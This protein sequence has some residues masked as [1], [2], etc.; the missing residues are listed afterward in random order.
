MI[1]ACLQNRMLKLSHESMSL[2]PHQIAPAGH[3]LDILHRSSSALDGSDMG[4]GKT[5]IAAYVA[6]QLGLPTLAV[7]PK[8][9]ISAWHRAAA[10][11]DDKI[12]V[13]GYEA[14]RTG[15]TPFGC[16]EHT[17]EPAK[18]Y[19]VCTNCQRRF[20]PDKGAGIAAD[21]CYTRPDGIHCFETRKSPRRLGKFYFS[22]EVALLIFD[23]VHRCNGTD[24]L[25]AEMLIAAKRGGH[26]V[27][28]LSATP[29][30]EPADLR[31]LGYVLG[32]HKLGDF[33]PW[34]SRLGYRKIPGGGLV[35][36][37][38]KAQ[39]RAIM[40]GINSQI[41]PAKGIRVRKS[42]IPDFPKCEIR[43]ELFDLG[44]GEKLDALYAEM[45]THLAD[46][47]SRADRTDKSPDHPLT[48]MLRASEE[49]ELLKVPL[50]L[51]LRAD[52]R[53]RGISVAMFVNYQRTIAALRERIPDAALIDGSPEGVRDRDEAVRLFR[54][55]EKSDIIL[56]N[57]AGNASISLDDAAGGHPRAGLVF[58]PFSA[59][60]FRQL[61]GR[62]PRHGGKS[63][64]FYQVIFAEGSQVERRRHSLISA[65]L[66]NL[67]SLTDADLTGLNLV[68][69]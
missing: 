31:A 23:E 50:M 40:A 34:L 55:N 61:T 33:Y 39:Q 28:G 27:I 53:A 52:Y 29:A 8:I 37:K 6:K 4:I 15:N 42:D 2:R 12:S 22:P 56:S 19:F 49:I 30:I 13:I 17:P 5:Y 68:L 46:L 3:L 67:D 32:L 16:W 59:V 24:S 66:D 14:L 57:A 10:A 44:S 11:F 48:R 18:K 58:P 43:A 65:K 35:W 26:R 62:L 51:E 21:P 38:S 1:G 9:S 20:E 41:F 45:A 47:R 7:V 25:N 60:L 54:N 69:D 36:M 63:D 64:S